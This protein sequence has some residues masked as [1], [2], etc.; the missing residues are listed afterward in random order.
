MKAVRFELSYLLAAPPERVWPIL[1]DTERLNRQVGLPPT[2]PESL[3]AEP[4]RL[5]RV[6]ARFAGVPL[7]W[8]EEPFEF[9]E[10]RYYR[11]RRRMLAGPIREFNGGMRFV[12]TP[13]GT[14]ARV[15]AEFVPANALGE[16]LIRAARVKLRRDWDRLMAGVRAHLAG[17][18]ETAYGEGIDLATAAV[19]EKTRARLAGADADF[20]QE[21]LASRL[22]EYLST[23]GDV[24]LFRIRP[25][26]LARRWGLDRHD[27]LRLCLR[28][29]H[30][31]VG[32]LDLSWDLLCPNCA[33]ASNRW[34][35]LDQVRDRAHCE[36]CQITFD[37][38]FD[39]AVEV[40]FR[41]NARFRAV[42]SLIYCSGG[43]R[44]TP[45]LVAQKVLSPGERA[46]MEIPLAAGRYRLR[47]LTADRA[48]P[49]FVG[50]DPGP[51]E[52]EGVWEE[53]C[54]RL[55]PAGGLLG[56][57]TVSFHLENRT[58]TR[59]QV[60]LERLGLYDDVATAAVVSVYQD[61]RDLF[62]SEVL[63]PNT[64]LGIQ[65]L[66]LLFTDLKGS[67]ALYGELGDA[68]AYALVR[69]HFELLQE[70][71]TRHGGGLVKTIGDAVM[72]AFPTAADAVACALEI[73]HVLARFNEGARQP[74]R[75]KVG[76]H[77]G[78][79]IA[80]RSYDERLDY[81]G[82]TVNLAARTHEQSRGDDVVVTEQ[83]LQD[84]AAAELLQSV[85][86]EAFTADLRGLGQ[87]RLYRLYPE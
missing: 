1:A 23:A 12:P 15:E 22:C 85:R 2:E 48:A 68:S 62:G 63:S 26:A 55:L 45:H 76:L 17:A 84:A 43:P 50:D 30:R 52:V 70:L 13:D 56:P 34:S 86:K 53:D 9:V 33:G 27:V 75:L 35:H 80:A 42:E 54:L 18:Q 38:N 74:I 87:V 59:Q 36:S 82:S 46:T 21:P 5:T 64:R 37:A 32:V 19:R 4:V 73:H 29:A 66:P 40:T 10:P 8:E 20:L 25:F 47:N 71:V 6:R 78:P 65:T 77:Q 11:V 79:C 60:I 14:E 58:A 41:P 69:D 81:F 3:G 31:G 24:E 44:N 61:F 51:E 28:A 16:Q 49:L 67:T 7:E 39:R 57:G 83:I 72:A